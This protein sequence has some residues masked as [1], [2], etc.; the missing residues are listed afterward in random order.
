MK[1]LVILFLSC[2]GTVYCQQTI[3]LFYDASAYSYPSYLQTDYLMNQGFLKKQGALSDS[4]VYESKG[5]MT[6]IYV[7]HYDKNQ[8]ITYHTCY[9]KSVEQPLYTKKA[10]YD[11]NGNMTEYIHLNASNNTVDRKNYEYDSKGRVIAYQKYSGAENTPEYNFHIIYESDSVFTIE[12]KLSS[13][14]DGVWGW[15]YT[16]G[17]NMYVIALEYLDSNGTILHA[18]RIRKSNPTGIL[19]KDSTSTKTIQTLNSNTNDDYYKVDRVYL[20]QYQ[21]EIFVPIVNDSLDTQHSEVIWTIK[22]A[23]VLI[24]EKKYDKNDR[25]INHTK[26]YNEFTIVLKSADMKPDRIVYKTEEIF[27]ATGQPECY[28]TYF[29]GGFSKM[30]GFYNSNGLL[31]K[32]DYYINKKLHHTIHYFFF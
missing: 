12:N 15:K 11:Q 20:D 9:M 23:D 6:S 14:Q 26:Y 16:V 8:R 13:R 27:K 31:E 5:K 21:P 19:C 1:T 2:I 22:K 7:W 4:M 32:M 10:N 25:L 3:P 30:Q 24:E 28:I 18:T 29:K 17:P